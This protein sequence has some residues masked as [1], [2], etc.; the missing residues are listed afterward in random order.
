M[1]N[2]VPLGAACWIVSDHDGQA[3][4][5]AQLLLQLLFPHPRTIA[6]AAPTIRQD[7]QLIRLRISRL[8]LLL[9]PAGQ[10]SHG[11][12]WGIG[13]RSHIDG[14]SIVRQIIDPVRN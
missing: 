10:G 1:L 13:G 2:W 3:I 5:V 8:S 4:A 7:E 6:I 14:A 12:F 9:P 11:K